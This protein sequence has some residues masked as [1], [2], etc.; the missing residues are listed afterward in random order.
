MTQEQYNRLQPFERHLLT[1]TK[2]NYVTA[3]YRKTAAE[4]IGVYNEIFKTKK[5]VTTCNACI[6]EVCRKLGKLY[7][8]F[9]TEK[10]TP[11]EPNT[12]EAEQLTEN[13]ENTPT[14]PKKRG[15]PRKN[16]DQ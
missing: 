13:A 10:S 8:E 12:T 16:K 15:R 5:T 11:T 14:A 2:A 4:L 7:F 1:A 6:L 9:Q 3:V